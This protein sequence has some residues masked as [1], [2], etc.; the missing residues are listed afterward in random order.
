MDEREEKVQ[1]E[2]KVLSLGKSLVRRISG[3]YLWSV[4]LVRPKRSNYPRVMRHLALQND[5]H[6]DQLTGLDAP[7]IFYRFLE[8]ALALEIRSGRV[9][10]ALVRFRLS[11]VNAELIS[12]ESALNIDPG[13]SPIQITDSQED[14][15][16]SESAFAVALFARFL[17][18]ATRSDENITRIGELTFL[19]LAHVKDEAELLSLKNR[20]EVALAQIDLKQGDC[21]FS[22]DID[23]FLHQ[24]GEEMLDFLERVDV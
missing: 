10:T 1:R 6:V 18:R 16:D 21:D 11:I 12:H 24:P 2:E 8:K 5:G 9:E 20:F 14:P 17:S 19:L 22:V 4:S 15:Y 3:P 23:C 13:S 7:D